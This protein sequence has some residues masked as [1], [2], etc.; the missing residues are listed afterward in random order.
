MLKDKLSHIYWHLIIQGFTVSLISIFIPIYL[1]T[2]GFNITAVFI[3]LLIQWATFGLLSPLYAKIIHKI[4]LKEIIYIR[5]PIYVAA[6]LLLSLMKTSM[7]IQQFYY[8]IPVL[9]GF[10]GAL[11]TLSITSLFAKF[12]GEKSQGI[13]VGKFLGLPK[14]ASI[15]GPFIG[16]LIALQFGFISLF[17]LVAVLLFVSLIPLS[18][19]KK[20]VD[21]PNFNFKRFK[22]FRT[23]IKEVVLL[24]SYGIK[25]FVLYIILPL[26]LYFASQNPVSLGLIV[27]LISFIGAFFTIYVGRLIDNHGLAK[28]IR[29]GAVLSAL[30]FLV[31]GYFA[32]S[33]VLYYL[34]LA[35]GI[36]SILLDIPYEEHLYHRSHKAQS[37][38]E[39][40]TFKEFSLATGRILLFLFLIVIVGT[41]F[42]AAFYFGGAF[43][44]IFLL[45]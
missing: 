19:I 15:I 21:H 8:F 37:P 30:L 45:F 22:N 26:A 1:L 28:L 17:I 43:A 39:F 44:L 9:I 29:I 13:K 38:L 40:L 12:L 27:S 24:N 10:S 36:I 20:N 42:N 14:L 34:S 16:G 33:E 25:G 7:L 3:F 2:I 11:Y 5:T 23:D 6:L 31:F 4:G 18:F 41:N 35:S 32:K